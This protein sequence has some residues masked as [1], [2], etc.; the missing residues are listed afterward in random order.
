MSIRTFEI[1]FPIL[2]VFVS[3]GG[4][5]AKEPRAGRRQ[6]RATTTTMSFGKG[7]RRDAET[8]TA[9]PLE[10]LPEEVRERL[11]AFDVDGDGHI[12][13]DELIRAAEVYR[14]SVRSVRRMTKII[15][16]LT[17]VL[18][19]VVGCIG[20]LTY[21]II[22]AT[23]ETKVE[24]SMLTTP[25]G[26]A[27]SVNTNQISIPVA[28]LAFMPAEVASNLDNIG[29]SSVDDTTL[30]YRRVKSVNVVT[31]ASVVVETTAGDVLTY[32]GGET[33]SI[34]LAAGASWNKRAACTKCSS[35]NVHVN[36]EIDKAIDKAID[37]FGTGGSAA[38][39]RKLL[40]WTCW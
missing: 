24:G 8:G 16:A 27:V 6:T 10:G 19:A 5:A 3:P 36:A 11:L 25:Y 15:I 21:G 9:I 26:D 39:G 35:L 20:G 2:F 28:A 23:K 30:Y 22:E 31:D 14:D 12:S 1:R 18:A 4:G 13:R 7:G 32:T 37:A 34:Q 33:I 40:S 17:A 38:N 29:F